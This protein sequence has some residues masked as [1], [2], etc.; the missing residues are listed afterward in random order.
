MIGD[1][2]AGLKVGQ[3]MKD[4]DSRREEFFNKPYDPKSQHISSLRSD[5]A[6]RRAELKSRLIWLGIL[7]IIAS[8]LLILVAR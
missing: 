6:L 3:I 7:I 5:E 2:N 1:P 4:G 8:I